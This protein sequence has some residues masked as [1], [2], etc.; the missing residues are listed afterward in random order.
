MSEQRMPATAGCAYSVLA[1]ALGSGLL[2][3]AVLPW[4]EVAV[5]VWV[6]L[7]NGGV[8]LALLV[9]ALVVDA[10]NRTQG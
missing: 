8:L 1:L 9:A 10:R 5:P 7:A 2:L 6:M 3:Y 4:L